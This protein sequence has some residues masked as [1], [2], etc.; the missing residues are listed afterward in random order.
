M[1]QTIQS[2]IKTQGY[3]PHKNS[4]ANTII[5]LKQLGYT[6]NEIFDTL[7]ETYRGF[8]PLL[9]FIAKYINSVSF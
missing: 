6:K 3:E 9:V 4:I 1:Y 8:E 5:Q 7:N 2:T